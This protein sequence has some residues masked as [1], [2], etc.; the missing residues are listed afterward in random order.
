M[1]TDAIGRREPH[2]F[3]AQLGLLLPPSKPGY[4]IGWKSWRFAIAWK[5][6]Q[7]AAAANG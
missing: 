7:A 4:F 3:G 2:I 6:P 1:Q 5:T